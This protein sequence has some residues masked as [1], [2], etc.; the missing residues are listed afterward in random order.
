[1]LTNEELEEILGR[2]RAH[3]WLNGR[4]D[5]DDREALILVDVDHCATEWDRAA[6]RR[7]RI[8]WS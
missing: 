7:I 3:A 8:I 6:L 4:L 2:M 5:F 1:M